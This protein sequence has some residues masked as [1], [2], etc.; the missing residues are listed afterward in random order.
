M[1][2]AASIW[3]WIGGVLSTILEIVYFANGRLVTTTRTTG[4]W[5]PITYT[6]T[7]RVPFEAWVWVLWAI[8]FG[9]RIVVLIWREISVNNG[10]KVACGVLTIITSA[11]LGGILTLCIPEDQL[12]SSRSTPS[13]S[14]YKGYKRNASGYS[15]SSE[16]SPLDRASKLKDLEDEYAT[17]KITMSEYNRR[18]AIIKGEEVKE[19]ATPVVNEEPTNIPE[20]EIVEEIEVAPIPEPFEAPSVEEEPVEESEKIRLV[21]EYKKLLDEGI[22]TQEEF[23]NKKKQLLK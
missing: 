17:G 2:K 12:W 15:N 19:E 14:K 8:W 1:K 6:T 5:Y 21:R 13:L 10:N 3:S 20:P 4:G 9:I 23:D 22:I 11:L 16:L 7:E 18:A